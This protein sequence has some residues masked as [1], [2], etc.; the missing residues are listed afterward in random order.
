MTLAE[1]W[2]LVQG[3]VYKLA[4]VFVSGSAAIA[5]AR[6]LKDKLLV[7]ISKLSEDEWAV[8]WRP[9]QVVTCESKNYQN[10]T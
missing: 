3:Q 7:F 8:Y 4:G 10:R 9:M 2:K 5:H 6:T 1:K